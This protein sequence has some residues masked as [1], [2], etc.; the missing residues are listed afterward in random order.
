MKVNEKIQLICTVGGS[1]D[2]I[3]R[4]IEHWRPARIHFICSQGSK[5]MLPEIE[6]AIARL[7]VG[8]GPGAMETL[9]VRNEEDL[10]GILRDLRALTKCVR[11]WSDRGADSVT[12]A[13]ITG[14]TKCMS[15]ALASV[16]R[17]WP[18][19]FSYVGGA[20]RSKGGLGVVEV[21]Q[22]SLKSISNPW[23]DL[24][25]QVIE[26]AVA[27]FNSGS[28][29]AAVQILEA[30]LRR[31]DDQRVKEE[32]LVISRWMQAHVDWDCFAFAKAAEKFSQVHRAGN[33]LRPHF[34]DVDTLLDRVEADR[35]RTSRLAG[36]VELEVPAVELI[37]ELWLNAMRRWSEGRL[38]D[39][40]ARLY[41]AAEAMAQHCLAEREIPVSKRVP[42]HMVP[43]PLRSEWSGRAVDGFLQ[44]GLQD[45]F[46]LLHALGH[47]HG[48]RFFDLGLGDRQRSPLNARNQSI[49]AHG[50]KP[51][52]PTEFELL[53]KM[54]KQ[55]IHPHSVEFRP[56]HLPACL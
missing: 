45:A 30:A 32:L 42:L 25:F 35:C 17:R 33:H 36:C 20:R 23:N 54:V 11:Q 3:C 51:V 34:D 31:I 9:V 52:S 21:G 26:D 12:V 41:R 29:G 4:S 48:S 6:E 44:V 27:A 50:V 38:D 28:Y 19:R 43:E 8:P 16:A 15:A 22:E 24:G 40:V 37:E 56:W 14:G 10:G 1:P 53:Q 5:A 46:R 7:Q 47:E 39:A 49:L 13:D 55:L 2:P 18:C